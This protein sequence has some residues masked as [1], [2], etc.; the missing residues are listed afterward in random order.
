MDFRIE[1][2]LFGEEVVPKDVLYGIHTVRALENESGLLARKR[3]EG[4][5]A[6]EKLTRPN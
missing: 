2:D 1:T 4:I 6:L 3:V 5:F